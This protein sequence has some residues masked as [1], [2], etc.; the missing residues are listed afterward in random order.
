[1]EEPQLATTLDLTT[2]VLANKEVLV[3]EL[4]GEISLLNVKSGIYFTLNPVGASV[5]RRI[6]E[7][8]C[9]MDIA[10]QLREEYDVDAV[11]CENDLRRLVTELQSLGLVEFIPA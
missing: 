10:G 1:M 7:P 2:K 6:Q 9:L 11:V 3:A 4:G 8:A 5:W